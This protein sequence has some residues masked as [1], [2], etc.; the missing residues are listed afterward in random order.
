M[1]IYSDNILSDIGSFCQG[2]RE[3]P[4]EFPTGSGVLILGQVHPLYWDRPL[5]E[6][7][8]SYVNERD[9]LSGLVRLGDITYPARG[10]ETV[11]HPGIVLMRLML[12]FVRHVFLPT[13]QIFFRIF[14]K[15]CLAPRSAKVKFLSLILGCPL[16]ILFIHLHAT[17][18]IDCHLDNSP[19]IKTSIY[20]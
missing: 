6:T 4:S 5:D 7:M 11:L 2:P 16:G 12:V 13:T 17:N 9:F 1:S 20:G 10:L 19:L 14:V 8:D 3:L 18:R 15:G